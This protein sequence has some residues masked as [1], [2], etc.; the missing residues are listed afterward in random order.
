MNTSWKH[1]G[2]AIELNRRGEFEVEGE[3]QSYPSLEEARAS[4]DKRRLVDAE[5][6]RKGGKPVG[7]LNKN[8]ESFSIRGLRHLA[9]RLLTARVQR[10][11]PKRRPRLRIGSVLRM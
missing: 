4:I 7:L 8:G 2:L 11:V 6:V 9:V 3:N 10:D 5:A 1:R